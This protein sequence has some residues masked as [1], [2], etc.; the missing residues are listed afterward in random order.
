[1]LGH[2]DAYELIKTRRLLSAYILL[3]FAKL[4]WLRTLLNAWKAYAYLV[5][6]EYA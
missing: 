6:I 1:M 5:L 4:K 3:V 2:E